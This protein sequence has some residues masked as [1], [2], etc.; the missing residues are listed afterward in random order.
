MVGAPF[1]ALGL[2]GAAADREDDWMTD[3]LGSDHM[4]SIHYGDDFRAGLR[5]VAPTPGYFQ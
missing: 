2:S 5:Y 3:R 1:G 4:L